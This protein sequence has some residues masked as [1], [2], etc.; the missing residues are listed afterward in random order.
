MYFYAKVKLI[1]KAMPIF[2][3]IKN[4]FYFLNTQKKIQEFKQKQKNM[5]VNNNIFRVVNDDYF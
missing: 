4:A 3:F 2:I 1:V 5:F